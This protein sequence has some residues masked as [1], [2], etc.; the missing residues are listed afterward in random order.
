MGGAPAVTPG[1][2]VWASE[3][4]PPI[5]SASKKAQ[6]PFRTSFW[7]RQPITLDVKVDR[8][9]ATETVLELGSLS[10]TPVP[11]P[12]GETDDA[13]YVFDRAY[14]LLFVGDAF[15]PYVGAPFVAEG[16]SAGYI[17][18]VRAVQRFPAKRII[19]GHPPL[20]RY[21]TK[22][23]MPG[24][25]AALADLRA[26]VLEGVNTARPLA[27][28]LR[29]QWLP[30]TLRSAPAAAMPFGV[31]RDTFVQRLYRERA[32]YWSADGSGMDDVRGRGE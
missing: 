20:T 6:N 18:A 32:G 21:W 17:D 5:S 23:A 4:F 22:E 28:A 27:D 8:P 31:M 25:E 16:S 19:H 10:L 14:E 15:M 2:T 11:G 13:L 24:L 3:R 30:A 12:S 7:G 29:E 9:V 1:A 26:H